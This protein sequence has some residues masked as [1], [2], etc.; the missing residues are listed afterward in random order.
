M[1]EPAPVPAPAVPA[2]AVRGLAKRFDRPVIAD[3]DLTIRAGELYALLGAN[4]AGKTTLFN[5]ITGGVPV[6]AGRVVFAS[7]DMTRKSAAVRAHLG[8]ARTFQI[9]NLF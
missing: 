8:I 3:L 7:T 2:L 4:G 5:A 1:H 6:S 9:T